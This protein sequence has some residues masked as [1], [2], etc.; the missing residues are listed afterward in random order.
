M[1]R[2]QDAGEP[3]KYMGHGICENFSRSIKLQVPTSDRLTISKQIIN[4]MKNLKFPP[5]DYRGMYEWI[6][7]LGY[8]KLQ[9]LNLYTEIK[10]KSN[11]I[12]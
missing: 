9:I 5:S 2:K 11:K 10:V 12:Q 6:F 7:G 1:I 3:S 8:Y 4:L